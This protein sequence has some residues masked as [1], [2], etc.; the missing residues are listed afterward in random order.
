MQRLLPSLPWW[1]SFL[2][3]F[4]DHVPFEYPVHR[5]LGPSSGRYQLWRLQS[6]RARGYVVYSLCSIRRLDIAML[7]CTICS[8]RVSFH[9]PI[10]FTPL[11]AW[12]QT[13]RACY[14]H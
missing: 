12:N 14:H 5:S 13:L 2:A 1:P 4:V 6:M 9:Q 11:T 7:L 8:G 3:R 10:L